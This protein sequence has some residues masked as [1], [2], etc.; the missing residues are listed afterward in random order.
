MAA[1]GHYI[2]QRLNE[3]GGPRAAL[4]PLRGFSM[5]NRE[6]K[7]LYNADA[8]MGYTQTLRSELSPGVRCE[9][10]DLHINDAEFA[11]HRTGFW[12]FMTN[13]KRTINRTHR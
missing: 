7:P 1:V 3:G 12:N 6:G 5:M 4:I 13:T 10:F 2:A 8:N 11:R 9:E